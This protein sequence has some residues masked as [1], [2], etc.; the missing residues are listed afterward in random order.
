MLAQ[1]GG[2][3]GMGG[4]TGPH[5]QAVATMDTGH[6]HRQPVATPACH[7]VHADAAA[8]GDDRFPLQSPGFG[9]TAPADPQGAGCSICDICHGVWLQAAWA[10]SWARP[11][12]VVASIRP[13][14]DASVSPAPDH[15]P[16]IA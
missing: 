16:P 4:H 15:R 13:V 5:T 8:L 1:H 2:V 6:T 3:Q 12:S 9:D 14:H 7:S 10:E 11:T